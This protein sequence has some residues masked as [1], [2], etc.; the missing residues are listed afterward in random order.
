MIL[1]DCVK[2]HQELI[3]NWTDIDHFAEGQLKQMSIDAYKKIFAFV[4]LMQ[5]FPVELTDEE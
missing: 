1:E 2:K 5:N 3:L 4:S